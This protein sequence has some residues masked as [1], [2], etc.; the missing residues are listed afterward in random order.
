MEID[1][2]RYRAG[3]SRCN[4]KKLAREFPGGL[5]VRIQHF[6]CC[7]PGSIPDP[8]TEISVPAAAGSG[9]K[10]GWVKEIFVVKEQF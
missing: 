3:T 2:C 6:Y 9:Q 10:G 5:V 8:G 7:S 4:Y 1:A